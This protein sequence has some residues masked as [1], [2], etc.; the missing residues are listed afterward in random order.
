MKLISCH[1]DGFGAISN[2]DYSF[3]KGLTG[4]LGENGAG[5]STLAA[6]LSAMLYGMETAGKKRT[7]FLDRKHFFPFG[8]GAF[9]GTLLFSTDN[10]DVYR[11]RRLFDE[12]TETQ[13]SVTVTKNDAPYDCKGREIG[14]ILF[15]VDRDAFIRTVFLS[16][17]TLDVDPGTVAQRL[18][19]TVSDDA[20][21]VTAE[22]AIDA[23]D[24]AAKKIVQGRG[25][26]GLYDQAVTAA[27]DAENALRQAESEAKNL[28]ALQEQAE[29]LDKTLD[30]ARS[31]TLWRSYDGI[32]ER[33]K[34][35]EEELKKADARFQN[36]VPDNA[37]LT[38]AEQKIARRDKI[39]RDA[40]TGFTPTAR[41]AELAAKFAP[42]AKAL[43]DRE[44]AIVAAFAAEQGKPADIGGY[45]LPKPEL[46]K[47][48]LRPVTE[49]NEVIDSL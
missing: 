28:P 17:E 7:D 8:G 40:E 48:W 16:A 10:G 44:Q 18:S 49:F 9:G 35:A 43:A 38:G 12:R 26:N 11:V 19:E 14:E 13:D 33:G 25:K 47:K 4:I 22:K 15:G 21:A 37:C 46:L 2:R 27:V 32:L 34:A 5:K 41:Q 30:A 29:A 20:D 1:I 45:Y 23:L 31:R 42:V 36:G 39:A 24:K 6:F 3:D